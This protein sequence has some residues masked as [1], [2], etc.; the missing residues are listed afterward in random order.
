MANPVLLDI[1]FNETPGSTVA[2]DYGPSDA[3]ASIT[4]GQFVNG[5]SHR[6]VNFPGNGYAEIIPKVVPLSGTYTLSVWLR[7]EITTSGPH[8]SWI[9]INFSGHD[10]LYLDLG[11]PLTF[12]S[13]VV[14][15]QDTDRFRAYVNGS[16]RGVVLFPAGW[17]KPIGWVVV[18]DNTQAFSGYGTVEDLLLYQGINDDALPVDPGNPTDPADPTN[19]GNPTNPNNPNY[20]ALNYSVNGVNFKDFGV[21]VSASSGLL[22]NTDM[23]EGL[24]MDWP[25]FHGEVVDLSAPR[26]ETRQ[27]SLKCFS[28]A[29]SSNDFIDKTRAFIAA[30]QKAGTQR[31]MLIVNDRVL[32]YEVYM[33]RSIG[34]DKKW[35]DGRMVGTFTLSLRE[36]EPVKRVLKYSGT[37]SASI[38][39][40]STKPV[41]IYWGD[42][43][44]TKDV[45]G[46]NVSRSHGYG[47]GG[48]HYIIVSGVIEDI[49]N[50]SS[51][52]SIVWNII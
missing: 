4:S 25:G 48:D 31:L 17:G 16:L 8:A 12:W 18:N 45:Y 40:T 32:V 13:Y 22:D 3:N 39:L 21:Y 11:S 51:N 42:G 1:P 30:F 35:S 7:A 19:P 20:M 26:Y 15:Q 27:I 37:G 41:N 23:K 46:S 33:D 52:A 2:Q 49:T 6:A 24:V 50:F 10:P 9:L 47:S 38:T 36:P 43:V 14:I 28:Y 34:Q 5:R 29:T 44:S